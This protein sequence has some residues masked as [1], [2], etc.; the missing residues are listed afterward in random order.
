MKVV[1]AG[2]GEVGSHLT[3]MLTNGDHNIVVIDPV[4]E[5]IRDLSETADFVAVGG[6]STSI[7]TLLKAGVDKADLFIAVNPSEEQDMNITSAILAKHIGAKKVIARINN[8]EYLT[9]E[10]KDIFTDIGIDHLLYPEK[11]AAKAIGDLLRQTGTTE[12]IDFAG[13]KLQIVVTKLEEGAPVIDFSIRDLTD[14]HSAINYR[15]VAISREGEVIIPDSNEEFKLHDMVYVI[16]NQAGIS[17]ALKYTGKTNINVNN[18]MIFGGSPIGI[19]LAKEL[20]GK[21]NIKLIDSNREKSLELAEYLKNTLVINADIRNTDVM[22]EEDLANM[23]AVVAL[24]PSSETNILACLA[25]KKAGVKKTIAEIENI[26]YIKLAE[27]VGIDTV[28][29][30]KLIAAGRIFRY[31]IDSDVQSIKYLTGSNAEILEF[32]AKPNSPVTRTKVRNLHFPKTAMLG[33]IV[34]GTQAYIVTGETEIKPYDRVVVF[35]LPQMVN[36]IGKYFT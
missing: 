10:N 30:K 3:K 11:I 20:E 2:I 12:Y 28:I 14:R 15:T 21:I 9:P 26:D 31:T 36:K 23:D 35:S 6:N 7:S 25:A 5:R 1:I 27:S 16:S 19:M 24:T 33:G 32:I 4:E 34:R 29:N 17:E 13:G 22:K 8:D 18:M